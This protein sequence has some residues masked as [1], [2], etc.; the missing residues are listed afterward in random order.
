MRRLTVSLFT[1]IVCCTRLLSIEVSST[2][3]G[4]SIGFR[5][6]APVSSVHTIV[7]PRGP[8]PIVT[9]TVIGWK[10]L[11]R[12]YKSDDTS[13][14]VRIMV[15]DAGSYD[16]H[17][18]VRISVNPTRRRGGV[19]ELADS[20]SLEVS[21]ATPLLRQSSSLRFP[22]YVGN[23]LNA[24]YAE[25]GLSTKSESLFGAV[26]PT[27][28]YLPSAPHVALRTSRDGV[29]IADGRSIITHEPRFDQA[30]LS[31]L[32]IFYRGDTIP[33]MVNDMTGNGVL[34]DDDVLFFPSR[35]P[36]GTS[37]WLDQNDTLATFFLSVRPGGRHPRLRPVDGTASLT[38]DRLSIQRR[39]EFDSGFY[40]LGSGNPDLAPEFATE[41]S[42]HEGFYWAALSISTLRASD[43]V[44]DRRPILRHGEV[45]SPHPSGSPFTVALS[46]SCL[47]ESRE[48]TNEHRTAFTVNG[49]GVAVDNASSFDTR[50]LPIT[51]TGQ[52]MMAGVNTFSAFAVGVPELR[53][54]TGYQS[55]V[56]IEAMTISG[57][58]L[59]AL[60]QGALDGV[61]A[62]RTA[63]TS[64]PYTGARTESVVVLD[65][66]HA[67]LTWFTGSARGTSLRLG[68]APGEIEAMSR[69]W[70][71]TSMQV[72]AM[73]DDEVHGI[74]N[75]TGVH[76]VA[77][78][79]DATVHRTFTT[80]GSAAAELASLPPGTPV[81]IVSA[82]RGDVAPL[83][84]QIRQAGGPDLSSELFVAAGLIGDDSQWTSSLA[85]G[86]EPRASVHV[87]LRHSSGRQ[88]SGS[89]M[90]PA[91][92]DASV[93]IRDEDALEHAIVE[94]AHLRNLA[95]RKI[96]ADVVY[97]AYKDM[98]AQ[99]RRLAEFRERHNKLRTAIVDVDDII[100]E[101]G[102]GSRSPEAIKAFLTHTWDTAEEPKPTYLV[103]VGNATW[104]PRLAIRA[105]NA[106]SRRPNQVPTYG[107]PS[108]DYWFGL[109][110]DPN[111]IAMPELIVGRIPAATAAEAEAHVSKIIAHDERPF[112]PW[113]RRMLYVGGGDRDNDQLCYIY[114][115]LLRDPFGTGL[116]IA[117]K[118]FCIDTVT[119]CKKDVVGSPGFEIRRNVNSGVQMLHFLG[120]GA[121]DLFEIPSWE[122]TDL[123]N[124]GKF[125]VLVTYACQTGAFSNPSTQCKNASYLTEPNRGFVAAIGSTGWAFIPTIVELHNTVHEAMRDGGLRRVGDI[126]Y[127]AKAPFGTRPGFDGRNTVM[128]Q[129]LLG[130]PLTTIRLDTA[131][132][133]YIRSDD[134]DIRDM[135][136]DR[137]L[138]EDD[139]S[140]IVSVT[141]RNAGMGSQKPVDVLFLRTWNGTTDTVT[142][143]LGDGLCAS[144]LVQVRL[145]IAG[146][147][148][149][150]NLLVVVDPS[151]SVHT[152]T[153]DDS[154]QLRFDVLSSSL[155]AIEPQP[156]WVLPATDALVR[157]LDPNSG[158]PS[159]YAFVVAKAPSRNPDSI[160]VVSTDD[161]ITTDQGIIDWTIPVTLEPSASYWLGA[162]VQRRDVQGNATTVWIPFVVQKEQARAAVPARRMLPIDRTIMLG[163]TLRVQGVSTRVFLKSGGIQTENLQADPTLLM[164]V[165]NEVYADNSYFRGFNILVVPDN[166]SIPREWVRFD[167][168]FDP[169]TTWTCCINGYM[170]DCLGYLRDSIRTNERVLIA[171]SLES[172]S[173]FYQNNTIDTLRKLLRGLGS[174]AIDTLRES[175]SF[176]MIGRRGLQPGEA[177]ERAKNAPDSMVVIDTTIPVL[178]GPSSV[179]SVTFGPAARWQRVIVRGVGGQG[180][181]RSLIIGIDRNGNE[182]ILDSINDGIGVWESRDG[183]NQWPQIYVRSTITPSAGEQQPGITD[184]W[185]EF[186]PAGEWGLRDVRISQQQPL[187]GDT[188]LADVSVRNLYRTLDAEPVTILAEAGRSEMSLERISE[189]AIA[190]LQ[191]DETIVAHLVVPTATLDTTGLLRM[192]VNPGGA[193]TELYTFNNRWVR[194]L[195]LREDSVPPDVIV[196]VDGNR[197]SATTYAAPEPLIHVLMTDNSSLPIG[198]STRLNVFINGDR[199]RPSVVKNWEFMSTA[200]AQERFGTTVPNVR[201]A[202]QFRYA[203]D[204]GRNNLLIRL[205]DA[206][207][208]KDT[209]TIALNVSRTPEL[210]GVL[211][212]PQPT[213]GPLRFAIEHAGSAPAL[214]TLVIADNQ[215]RQ[216]ARLPLVLN[217]GITTVQW[218]GRAT[219]GETIATGTYHYRVQLDDD[220]DV[221]RSGSFLIV[222]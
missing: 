203:L 64:I 50:I 70:N 125:G 200:R 46:Y 108:S 152:T 213:S 137:Q 128:Q 194:T 189:E 111:D 148:G 208:N 49:G 79:G 198:D 185:A 123:D 75:A 7:A 100:D 71:G 207:G 210:S 117:G 121:P 192:S 176:A 180:G 144:G 95:E 160:V 134:I 105:G 74:A 22:S 83:A 24:E 177:L 139:D 19:L 107:R 23:V 48:F 8:L 110:D 30:L 26:A 94:P 218:N 13:S 25:G 51:R 53:T 18:L 182:S 169:D 2:N 98:L 16:G 145:P 170:E 54:Q 195:L 34:D 164:K 36:R 31:D 78:I 11:P 214:A 127:A 206:T 149:E 171:V 151:S 85:S 147:L 136:G 89:V 14:S 114:E 55:I 65:T 184:V 132:A 93:M 84:Q 59:P 216:I 35:Q 161:E 138:N 72:T 212:T 220:N 86:A 204:E 112:E 129:N 188:I 150:H 41:N 3:L 101:F 162:S 76:I 178:P 179:R 135:T 1:L 27:K 77:R 97:I 29:A 52:T 6:S 143:V 126:L 82:L 211:T 140:A 153:A 190:S 61:V 12:T 10:V 109:L 167:T 130:D 174:A 73:M 191:R 199:M 99:T 166:D 209:V 165:G 104:D 20:I 42:L 47:V 222:R 205:E 113:N 58:V 87:F 118:P 60:Y 81:G 39:I 186:T 92:S 122:P 17:R 142:T 193:T 37:T 133:P 124:A 68:L 119:I 187:R 88:F 157:V 4:L 173:A 197:V 196:F 163:D 154:V 67:T 183:H 172:F 115:Y 28:W 5:P 57:E 103:L 40:H 33:L 43:T 21:F 44:V 201:A 102:A 168:Y 215:G 221:S 45:L 141:V 9:P 69:P 91:G 155:V 131:V 15:T 116:T 156:H 146:K 158:R 159:T 62:A 181:I 106:N 56:G 202:M 217:V 120:H 38:T 32:V 90:L 63:I 175:A 96:N 80:F 219:S 66:A